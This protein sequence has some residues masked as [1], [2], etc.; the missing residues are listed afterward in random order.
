MSMAMR[1][2]VA[3]AIEDLARAIELVAHPSRI[4]Q[5]AEDGDGAV[6]V[7]PGVERGAPRGGETRLRVGLL[8]HRLERH[9]LVDLGLCRLVRR[10]REQ[11]L[12]LLDAAIRHVDRVLEPRRIRRR[13]Q[14]R[15]RRTR[16]AEA[17]RD[18]QDRG[19][20]AVSDR[21]G[22]TSCSGRS[23]PGPGKAEYFPRPQ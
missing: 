7:Q 14:L 4:R 13:R 9:R 5:P 22:R 21:H 3:G 16:E 10:A 6:G 8:G 15:E 20:C 12:R 17:Q 23:V 19:K 2:P 11:L 1:Q 18:R